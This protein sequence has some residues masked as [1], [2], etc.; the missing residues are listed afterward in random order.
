MWQTV[1]RAPLAEREGR[2]EV[3]ARDFEG[4]VAKD[5]RAC[6]RRGRRGGG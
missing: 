2:A 3:I 1:A 4:L 6:T 5:G